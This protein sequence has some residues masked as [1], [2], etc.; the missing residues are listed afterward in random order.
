M[1]QPMLLHSLYRAVRSPR[2]PRLVLGALLMSVLIVRVELLK[3]ET[4]T[5]PIQTDNRQFIQPTNT[6][7]QQQSCPVCC[8]TT[9]CPHISSLPPRRSA[10]IGHWPAPAEAAGAGRGRRERGL[11]LG[12]QGIFEDDGGVIGG[13]GALP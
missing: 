12:W 4:H 3:V 5:L 6:P 10:R 2:N 13:S 9:D 8:R 1:S 11:F 7:L